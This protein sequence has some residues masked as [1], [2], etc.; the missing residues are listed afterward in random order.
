MFVPYYT[1]LYPY[2]SSVSAHLTSPTAIDFTCWDPSQTA[3]QTAQSQS[4]NSSVQCS[5]IA[6]CRCMGSKWK[7]W[8]WAAQQQGHLCAPLHCT[9]ESQQRPNASNSRPTPKVM[10]IIVTEQ[11]TSNGF[12]D[13]TNS[14]D[15]HD[16]WKNTFKIFQTAD[17]RVCLRFRLQRFICTRQDVQVIQRL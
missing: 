5:S 8:S 3:S 1:S 2:A 7:N 10:A 12:R 15:W 13:Q 11:Q 17:L 14:Q 4:K 9:S 6:N 16:Y